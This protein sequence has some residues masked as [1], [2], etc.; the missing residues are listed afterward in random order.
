MHIRLI[1][2]MAKIAPLSIPPALAPLVGMAG[3]A[4]GKLGRVGKLSVVEGKETERDWDSMD[5]KT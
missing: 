5:W 1:P 2:K 3:F 4:W